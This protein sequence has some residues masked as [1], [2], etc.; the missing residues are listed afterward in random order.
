MYSRLPTKIR[1]SKELPPAHDQQ[2]YPGLSGSPAAGTGKGQ[3]T[4]GG[5]VGEG[6]GEGQKYEKP[7]KYDSKT[8]KTLKISRCPF[9]ART[10]YIQDP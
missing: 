2:T 1:F 4:C 8:L 3:V 6:V 9:G 5:G 7:S 10:E